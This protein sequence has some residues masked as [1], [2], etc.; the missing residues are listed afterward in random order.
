MS[1]PAVVRRNGKGV[2]FDRLAEMG[3]ER[4]GLVFGEVERH[5]GVNIRFAND[6]GEV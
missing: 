4:T 2:V 3:D 1:R 5:T 6:K